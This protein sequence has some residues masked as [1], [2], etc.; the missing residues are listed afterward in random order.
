MIDKS[1]FRK[2][3]TGIYTGQD[4]TIQRVR[5]LDYMREI[6]AVPVGIDG[7]IRD[8]LTA[9][10]DHVAKNGGNPETDE[11]TIK[12]FLGRGII[13]TKDEVDGAGVITWIGTPGVWVGEADQCPDN[14]V[15]V[16]E[17]GNDADFLVGQISAFSFSLPGLGG[18]G[19]TFLSGGDG[20]ATG[21]SSEE[22]RAEAVEPT[23]KGDVQEP[24][25]AA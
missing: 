7:S 5:L 23:P 11:K 10:Q 17:L 18:P 20:G 14:H 4:F 19:S 8:L 15:H 3:V 13:P 21:P 9:L 24:P 12:F 16:S 22:I 6:G 25:T 2:R 1:K